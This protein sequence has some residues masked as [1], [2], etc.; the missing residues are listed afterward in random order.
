MKKSPNTA[1]IGGILFLV[2][3][4]I[5]SLVFLVNQVTEP[6]INK[7][8][9]DSKNA[10]FTD[11]F[12]EAKE[13]EDLTDE[14]PDRG[15]NILEIYKALDGT[16]VMGY[17]YI[18]TSVGYEQAIETLVAID[19]NDN[20]VKS[21]TILKQNETP[22]LGANAKEPEFTDQFIGLPVDGKV[23]ITKNPGNVEDSEVQSITASTITSDA[24]ALGVNAALAHFD[25]NLRK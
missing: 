6:V 12:P 23:T 21:I 8:D 15:A 10:S 5:A 25:A 2:C 9:E 11:V 1:V 4:I 20:K 24:V 7:A 16:D 18:V 3:A 19:S 17:I 13:F 22:G 14:F